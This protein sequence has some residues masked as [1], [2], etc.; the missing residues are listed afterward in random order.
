MSKETEAFASRGD[1]GRAGA[2]QSR[3]RAVQRKRDR[4]IRDMTEDEQNWRIASYRVRSMVLVW[5]RRLSTLL[6][7]PGMG[8]H[9]NL[10][11][12]GR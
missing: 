2:Q 3:R 1:H 10:G 5:R 11:Q 4:F 7:D 9:R 12:C 6:R 8:H